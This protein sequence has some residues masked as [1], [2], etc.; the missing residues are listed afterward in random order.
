M[1]IFQSFRYFCSEDTIYIFPTFNS[2][3][4]KKL[5]S[6]YKK[7]IFADTNNIDILLKKND[8]LYYK[9]RS[10]I[11]NQPIDLP[12]SLIFIQFGSSFNQP[13]K[14]PDKLLNVIFGRKFNQYIEFPDSIE[15]IE[16]G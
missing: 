1:G 10:S 4:S 16:F 12:N 7:L 2:T 3:L 14:L 13:V 8:K 15:K 9:K 6:K 11:F 5:L